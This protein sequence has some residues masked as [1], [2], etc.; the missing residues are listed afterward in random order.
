MAIYIIMGINMK[1]MSNFR[2]PTI[3]FHFSFSEDMRH[4]IVNFYMET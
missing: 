2:I 4:L 3:F 1:K